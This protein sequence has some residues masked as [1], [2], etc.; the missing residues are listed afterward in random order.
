MNPSEEFRRYST[1]CGHMADDLRDPAS[2]AMWNGMAQRWLRC[3]ELYDI[4]Q[5]AVHNASRI[6][7]HRR[8]VL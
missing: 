7:L 5:S 1:E 6:K 8:A 4:Q 3:A 2:K